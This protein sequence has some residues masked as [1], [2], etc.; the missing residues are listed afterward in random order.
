MKVLK[1][2]VLLLSCIAFFIQ[3]APA[4]YF[5]LALFGVLGILAGVQLGKW[6]RSRLKPVW[7]IVLILISVYI[8][9]STGRVF[10]I[11]WAPSSQ[12]KALL[13]RYTTDTDSLLNIFCSL[14]SVAAFPAVFALLRLLFDY[15]QRIIPILREE[16]S[17]LPRTSRRGTFIKAA[18]IA[19]L[20]LIGAVILGVVLL[21]AVYK[22]P[23]ERVDNNVR[24]SAEIIQSEGDFPIRYSWC[25]SQM[26][27]YTDS[28]M[29]LEAAD[30]SESSALERALMAYR[31]KIDGVSGISNTLVSHYISGIE[32]TGKTSYSRYW[33]GYQVIFKPLLEIMDYGAIRVL[34]SIVQ[35]ALVILISVLLAKRNAGQ[36]IL[37]FLCAYLMLNP[38]TM[39]VSMQYSFCFYMI[40]LGCIAL[41]LLPEK[42]R[43]RYAYLVFL[44]IGIFTAYFDF[45]TYP[46]AAFGIPA[47]LYT[48]LKK[49]DS[50][51]KKLEDLIRFGVV[52]CFGYGGM[53]VSKWVVANLLTG[54]DTIAEAVSQFS[55]RTSTKNNY[56]TPFTK[57]S[58]ILLN[59]GEF[60]FTPAS[61]ICIVFALYLIRKIKASGSSGSNETLARFF[62]YLVLSFAPIVWYAFASNHSLIHYFM[63]NKSCVVTMFAI[64]AGLVDVKKKSIVSSQ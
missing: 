47:V 45:L 26:F 3:I 42:K 6:E 17:S 56:G 15:V 18:G 46:I 21:T 36:Y 57:A 35:V 54:Y 1:K 30:D 25:S 51:T 53:W 23:I 7:L 61:I 59:C 34:N 4:N 29:L 16:R 58:C 41:L 50:L 22:L 13:S 14:G 24:N 8:A 2:V 5:A 55:I 49:E 12:L 27:N 43:S 20:N 10:H 64:L 28:I 19:A 9:Y 63:A 39:G 31:G 52:W 48:V 62:P 11:I 38:L 44:N 40:A 60:L 33:H 37:P 32:Y